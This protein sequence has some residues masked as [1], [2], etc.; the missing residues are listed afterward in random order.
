[1]GKVLMDLLQSQPATDPAASFNLMGAIHRPRSASSDNSEIGKSLSVQ[2]QLQQF[3][4]PVDVIIDFSR[5]DF[6]MEVAEQCAKNHIAFVSGTTGFTN[7]QLEHLKQLSQ[8]TPILYS[9]NMSIGVNTSFSLVRLM[10]QLLGDYADIEIIEAHHQHKIDAPSGTALLYG[11]VIAEQQGKKLSD[12]A[13]FN[14]FEQNTA[15][16]KGTIGFSS[17]RS[18]EIVGEHEI[19]FGMAGEQLGLKHR[20]YS[21]SVFASG[22]INAAHWLMGKPAG[23]YKM[24]D[25]LDIQT[26]LKKLLG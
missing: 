13:T 19:L 10:T 8:Q 3:S 2:Q 20:A 1:M 12:V 7:N 11:E 25:V 4:H 9:A 21:R 14:R 24:E 5:P 18:G 23:W 6:A 22:A 16:Q 15:R 17:I 26:K